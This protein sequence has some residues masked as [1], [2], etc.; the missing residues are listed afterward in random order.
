MAIRP[1]ELSLV[2]PT[3]AEVRGSNLV[4]WNDRDRSAHASDLILEDFTAIRTPTEIVE[5][6]LRYGSLY[7]YKDHKWRCDRW[8][9]PLSW[10]SE[11]VEIV[12]T[13]REVGVHLNDG[14]RLPRTLERRLEQVTMHGFIESLPNRKDLMY[15]S[16]VAEIVTS[17]LR[18]AR[19]GPEF[20]WNLGGNRWAFGVASFSTLGAFCDCALGAVGVALVLEL[21]GISETAVCSICGSDYAPERKP[22]AN[23]RSYCQTCRGSSEVWRRLKEAQRARSTLGDSLGTPGKKRGQIG[24]KPGRRIAP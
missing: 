3:H 2:V 9:E 12:S 18:T 14:V 8:Y 15:R 23:R 21:L 22:A 17:L 1:R 16:A 24:V 19:L 7:H 5:F 6:A 13:I 11:W 20:Y 10:W 4:A